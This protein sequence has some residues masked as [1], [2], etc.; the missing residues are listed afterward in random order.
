MFLHILSEPENECVHLGLG[1]ACDS[2]TELQTWCICGIK[3]RANSFDF[4]PSPFF[5]Q[6]IS[7]EEYR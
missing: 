4:L 6:L 7:P 1:A 5:P 2:V 3:E